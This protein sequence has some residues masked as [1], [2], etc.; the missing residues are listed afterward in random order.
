[1]LSAG[2]KDKDSVIVTITP[3]DGKSKI[4]IIHVTETKP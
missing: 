4:V 2:E 3:E 1:M